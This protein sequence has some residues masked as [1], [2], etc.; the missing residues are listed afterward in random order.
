MHSLGSNNDQ[1]H[2]DVMMPYPLYCLFGHIANCTV[3]IHDVDPVP[4][5]SR[6]KVR[7]EDMGHERG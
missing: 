2:M 6:E 5:I 1:T 3:F 7:R 4:G